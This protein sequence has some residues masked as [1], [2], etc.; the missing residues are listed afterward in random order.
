MN[1]SICSAKL[2]VSASYSL[3]FINDRGFQHQ[4]DREKSL[5]FLGKTNSLTNFLG[6]SK[7]KVG[8]DIRSFHIWYLWVVTRFS[9]K[10]FKNLWLGNLSNVKLNTWLPR[11]KTWKL[12]VN[13]FCVEGKRFKSQIHFVIISRDFCWPTGSNITCVHLLTQAKCKL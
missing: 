4:F 10:S 6:L 1:L 3:Q 8:K 13:A 9:A 12:D 11:K 5:I 2:V 7:Y